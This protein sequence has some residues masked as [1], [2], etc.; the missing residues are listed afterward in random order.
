MTAVLE[1]INMLLAGCDLSFEQSTELMDTVFSGT[2]EEVKI[3][4][5]L[6][7]IRIK[8]PTAGELAGFARSLRS[9]AVKIETGLDL[10]VD[11]CGTGGSKVKTFNISTASALVAAGAGAKIAKHGNRAITSSCGSA[12]VLL[13]LGVKI[14]CAP[15]RVVVCI[16][17]ANIGFMFAPMFHPAMKYVQPIRKGLGFMTVFNMLGPL[18]NPAAASAQ[19]L[20]VPDEKLMPLMIEALALLGAKHVMVVHS[21]G[22]DEISTSTPTKIFHLKAGQIT[23][24]TLDPSAF[25]FSAPT[26]DELKGSDAVTNARIVRDIVTGSETGPKRDIVILNAAAAIIVAGLADDF[27]SAIDLAAASIDNGGASKCL[28]ILIKISNS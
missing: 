12:D 8:G 6:T 24:S 21:A 27:Q 9:H 15:D 5:I 13:A 7:A 19:V 22:L 23:Q 11:T 18:A 26:P 1:Y 14:D 28:E 10:L 2:V 17:Q 20:G 4:A 16:K 3:A 25:G